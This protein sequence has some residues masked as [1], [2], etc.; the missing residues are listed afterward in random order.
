MGRIRPHAHIARHRR[1]YVA[2]HPLNHRDAIVMLELEIGRLKSCANHPNWR[3]IR[4]RTLE[5]IANAQRTVAFLG[6]L[7]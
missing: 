2:E 6:A 1:L 4:T 5:R 7:K 3:A